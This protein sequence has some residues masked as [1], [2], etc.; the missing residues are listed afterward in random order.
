[1]SGSG[2]NRTLRQVSAMS[3][4][5]SKADIER[6]PLRVRFG[7]KADIRRRLNHVRFT[8]ESGHRN[9]GSASCR[10]AQAAHAVWGAK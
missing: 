10:A 5:P 7:P 2:Q 1:M 4:L 9:L 3:A 6:R 8:P